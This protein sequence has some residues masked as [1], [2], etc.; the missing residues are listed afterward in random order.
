MQLARGGQPVEPPA[1]PRDIHHRRPRPQ[2]DVPQRGLRAGRA[3]TI[4]TREERPAGQH[5]DGRVARLILQIVQREVLPVLVREHIGRRIEAEVAMGYAG[6]AQLGDDLLRERGHEQLARI[7][8]LE[9]PDSP[10]QPLPLEARRGQAA[11]AH[12]G[13]GAGVEIQQLALLLAD[14]APG[15]PRRSI[16][17]SAASI[18]AGLPRTL[19]IA[20]AH[21]LAPRTVSAARSSRSPP[22]P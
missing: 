19:G 10:I 21:P 1:A 12:G 3:S 7:E 16:S 11:A 6:P 13:V 9:D 17:R 8:V 14:I 4:A 18:H 20:P 2:A 5:D 22:D 15:T